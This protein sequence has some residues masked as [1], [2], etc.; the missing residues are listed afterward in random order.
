MSDY[1]PTTE[2]VRENYSRSF[3]W[4][5]SDPARVEFF[6]RWLNEERAK[7]WDAALRHVQKL[8]DPARTINILPDRELI[9]LG[10]VFQAWDENPYRKDT[11]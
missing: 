9:T 4:G 6:D 3:T 7:V 5:R 1:T 2:E 8:S 10:D 11:P